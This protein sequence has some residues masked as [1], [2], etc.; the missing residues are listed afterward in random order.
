MGS[1]RGQPI[2]GGFSGFLFGIF[3]AL[4]LLFLS[5]ISLD[6]ILIYVLP[7]LFLV[8]GVL[9]GRFTPLGRR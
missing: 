8:V 5:V 3:L 4:D 2:L 9:L 1:G 6:S 7:V